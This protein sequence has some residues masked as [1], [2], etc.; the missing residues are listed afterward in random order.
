MSMRHKTLFFIVAL[1]TLIS[2][3]A[4]DPFF[5]TKLPKEEASPPPCFTE[6]L[7]TCV[8]KGLE[9]TGE[10]LFSSPWR[11]PFYP[12]LQHR[13]CQGTAGSRERFLAGLGELWN[14]EKPQPRKRIYED[15]IGY[16]SS[17]PFCGWAREIAM[18]LLENVETR[19]FFFNMIR[20]NCDINVTEELFALPDAPVEK[21]NMHYLNTR[22]YSTQKEACKYSEH[23]FDPWSDMNNLFKTGCLNIIEWLQQHRDN[24]EGTRDALERCVLKNEIRYREADCLHALTVIDRERA[25]SLVRKDQR[26]AYGSFSRLN[27]IARTLLRFPEAGSLET[28]LNR[29]GLIPESPV[30]VKK[31]A[32]PPVLPTDVFE[33]YGQMLHFNPAC[34]SQRYCKHAPLLY[35]LSSLASPEL[36]NII[37]EEQW[38]ALEHIDFG[39]GPIKVSTRFQAH[40]VTFN[41]REKD[42]T[43][44]REHHEELINAVKNG[45]LKSHVI[46]IYL[47]GYVYRIQIR[48]LQ[49]WYDLESLIGGLNHILS[50]LGSS[51]RFVALQPYC[52]PCARVLAAPGKGLIRGTFEGLIVVVEPFENIW[53]EPDFEPRLLDQEGSLKISN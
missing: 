10:Q 25:V 36:D 14:S 46:N 29:H 3:C 42:G 30:P 26:R 21:E 37:I 40:S 27:H 49:G 5:Y 53:T 13:I 43:F 8:E 16:C 15:F 50:V 12:D 39:T 17:G 44:D 20:K 4:H 34:D 6:P 33:A 19:T 51:T 11:F 28:E 23:Q 18:D 7:K 22:R 2:G 24:P 52:T 47:G 1:F 9:K 31:G 35:Q 41:V 45:L 48:N 38:P 32:L